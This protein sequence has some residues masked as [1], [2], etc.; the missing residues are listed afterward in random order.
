MNYT[1]EDFIKRL[2]C[3]VKVGNYWL[4]SEHPSSS[5]DSTQYSWTTTES[6]CWLLID[7]GSVTMENAI[8]T[9]DFRAEAQMENITGFAIDMPSDLVPGYYNVYGVALQCR[10]YGDFDIIHWI[11]CATVKVLKSLSTMSASLRLTLKRTA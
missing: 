11:P 8:V 5:P 10:R 9:L 2:H 3:K 4:M 7:N 1:G 6:S